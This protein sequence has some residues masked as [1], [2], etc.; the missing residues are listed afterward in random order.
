[1]NKEEFAAKLN[2]RD[3]GN[4]LTPDERNEAKESGL[5][6][7]YGASDELVEFEGVISDELSGYDGAEF[8]LVT[9]GSVLELIDADD[10]ERT[11]LEV[12]KHYDAIPVDDASKVENQVS[13][14]WEPE[15][16]NCSWLIETNLPH[17]IFDIMEDG[18]LFCRGVVIDSKDVKTI[19]QTPKQ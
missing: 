17:A 11:L 14:K 1:M 5:I 4:E 3:Y 9:P 15:D 13:A 18:G 19:K 8:I 16:P 6:V 10:D 2:G 7:I 12:F